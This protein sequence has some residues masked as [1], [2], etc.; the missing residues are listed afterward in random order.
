MVLGKI[1]LSNGRRHFG[2]TRSVSVK[3]SHSQGETIR[4]C[5]KAGLVSVFFFSRLGGLPF[6]TRQV[7]SIK[8]ELKFSDTKL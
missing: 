1:I 6:Y 5:A 8:R 7:F 4:V 2:P 3:G